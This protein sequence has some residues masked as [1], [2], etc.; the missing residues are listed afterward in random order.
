MK[1]V[2]LRARN[3]EKFKAERERIV[4]VIAQVWKDSSVCAFCRK[5]LQ[6]P[7]DAR[8]PYEVGY[9]KFLD[10]KSPQVE[11]AKLYCAKHFGLLIREPPDPKTFI[12][13]KH[14]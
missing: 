9:V 11:G 8:S 4:R 3:Y 13:V 6:R 5:P 10:P 14:G 7:G 1:P 12:M 2:G